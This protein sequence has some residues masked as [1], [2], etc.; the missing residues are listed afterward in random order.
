MEVQ[1]KDIMHGKTLKMIL[2][3]LV[4]VYGWKDLGYHINI[5]CF[6]NKPSINSSL[7]FLRKTEWART[8][9]ENF[10]LFTLKHNIKPNES[11]LNSNQ[12]ENV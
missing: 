8:K 3:Y 7:T 5:K 1:N 10:Y 4:E 12:N 9:V 2:E 6:N 11:Y